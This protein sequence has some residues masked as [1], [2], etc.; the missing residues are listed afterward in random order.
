MRLEQYITEK[1]VNSIKN[2]EK[3]YDMF[4]NPS[5]KE[6]AEIESQSFNGEGFRFLIDFKEKKVYMWSTEVIHEK[7]IEENPSIFPQIIWKEYWST[8]LDTDRFMS[9]HVESGKVGSDIWRAFEEKA[10]RLK[11]NIAKEGYQRAKFYNMER[12]DFSWLAKYDINP[13]EAK[14]LVTNITRHFK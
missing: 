3:V 5:K 11:G 13:N 7:M 4:V 1:Y 9:G 10:K 12:N 2:K 6:I 14:K 8:G